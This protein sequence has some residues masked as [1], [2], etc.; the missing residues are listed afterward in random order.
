MRSAGA[1]AKPGTQALQPRQYQQDLFEAARKRNVSH[2]LL[3][4]CLIPSCRIMLTL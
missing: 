4:S 2:P 1:A 3:P